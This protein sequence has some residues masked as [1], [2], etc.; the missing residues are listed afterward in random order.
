MSNLTSIAVVILGPLVLRKGIEF[1]R[2][3]LRSSVSG[4]RSIPTPFSGRAPPCELLLLALTL[5]LVSYHVWSLVYIVFFPNTNRI[6]DVFLAS[7][8]PVNAASV[9]L[10]ERV[11][12]HA[13]GLFERLTDTYVPAGA[14]ADELFRRLTSYE[15]RKIYLMVGEEPLLYCLFCVRPNDYKL[16][17]LPLRLASYGVH[18]I[19]FGIL[20]L[21]D[22]TLTLLNASLSRKPVISAAAG[23]D[24]KT[25]RPTQHQAET[26][27]YQP[28]RAA[29]RSS[30]L[31]LL[32]TGLCSEL[33]AL[34]S[35]ADVR[36]GQGR[37]NHWHVNILLARHAL[38]LLIS[39]VVYFIPTAPERASVQTSSGQA[40][41]ALQGA[42]YALNS[43]T[44]TLQLTLAHL[45]ALTLSTDV[46]TNDAGLRALREAKAVQDTSVTSPVLPAS[47]RSNLDGSGAADAAPNGAMP[48]TNGNHAD[49]DAAAPAL[50]TVTTPT[51]AAAAAA[52]E[53]TA[54]PDSARQRQ[55]QAT[56]VRL[57]KRAGIDVDAVRREAREA[58]ET[59]L[60]ETEMRARE[61]ERRAAEARG[62]AMAA[63]EA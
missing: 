5:G 55:R 34:H 47:P 41:S 26:V 33:F 20:T 36:N 40:P 17:T 30:V 63:G 18:F 11:A 9:L 23:P 35:V 10:R 2:G 32:L 59:V 13:Q 62:R 28:S 44:S 6:T 42:L 24:A 39:L 1:F 49:G 8:T 60:R 12:K 53:A 29:W 51:T 7:D 16:Y 19:L 37:W 61:A 38:M 46:V 25:D 21:G 50:P 58:A 3:G 57:A 48:A 15:G 45:Q 27:R 54:G 14:A 56:L 43:T 22:P 31:L 52:S 4:L